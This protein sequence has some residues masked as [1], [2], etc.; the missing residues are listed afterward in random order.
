MRARFF[1]IV[2]AAVF[3]VGAVQGTAL[4]AIT[5][6]KFDVWTTNESTLTSNPRVDFYVELEDSTLPP[7][8]AFSVVR[9]TAPDGVTVFDY[10]ADYWKYWSAG[11]RYF[12]FSKLASD[13]G[14]TI[15]TGSYKLTVT[16]KSDPPRTVTNTDSLTNIT[17]LPLVTLKYPSPTTLT[18][19]P[20]DGKITWSKVT[21]AQYYRVLLTE[22][23]G[24]KNFVYD[25]WLYNPMHIYVTDPK[26]TTLSLTLPKGALQA[27]YYY[28]VRI[29]ARDSDKNT[30][31]RSRTPWV[32]FQAG[33]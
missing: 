25:S 12:F 7:P 4:A 19:V 16:D 26:A 18:V 32:K 8:D 5:K 31:R 14:G 10:S 28:W 13:F 1:W 2:V 9:I 11:A 27:G 21:G 33:Q 23:S 29:E 30:M 15:P 22:D 20:L 6:C 24:N 3:V 17:S